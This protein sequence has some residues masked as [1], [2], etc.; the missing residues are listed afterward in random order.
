MLNIHE[1]LSSAR[2]IVCESFA[3]PRLYQINRSLNK[4]RL[5]WNNVF[6][7]KKPIAWDKIESSDIEEVDNLDERAFND[8][9]KSA[10]RVK[11]GKQEPDFIIFGM[12]N[13]ELYCIYNPVDAELF[14]TYFLVWR[15]ADSRFYKMNQK[16]QF[17]K[18][19]ECDYLLKV[20]IDKKYTTSLRIDRTQSKDGMLPDLTNDDRKSVHRR[21]GIMYTDKGGLQNAPYGSYYWECKRIAEKAVEK[22]HDIIAANA[23]AKLDSTEVDEKVQDILTRMSKASAAVTANPSKYDSRRFPQLLKSIYYQHSSDQRGD[24]YDVGGNNSLLVLYQEYCNRIIS[25]KTDSSYNKAND[26]NK[27]VHMRKEIMLQYQYLDK[28]LKKYE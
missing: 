7:F 9:F 21:R 28:E 10:R 20:Y 12:K 18:L 2:D 6:H 27:A 14:D 5:T 1:Y 11:A 24:H 22:W 26:M 8:I 16:E 4:Y 23:A 3:D 25:I 19:S 15:S 13:E 17:N